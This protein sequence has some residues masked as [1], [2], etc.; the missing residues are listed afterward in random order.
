MEQEINNFIRNLRVLAMAKN[1]IEVLQNINNKDSTPFDQAYDLIQNAEN[2]LI[3]II[4]SNLE[5]VAHNT[6]ANI[7]A[8]A[9]NLN[10]AI[11]IISNDNKIPHKTELMNM[12]QSCA[13]CFTTENITEIFAAIKKDQSLFSK[14]ILLLEEICESKYFQQ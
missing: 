13:T 14:Q 2:S 6:I 11:D 8:P 4:G 12:L 1:A 5:K 9:Q 3:N 7:A 10:G